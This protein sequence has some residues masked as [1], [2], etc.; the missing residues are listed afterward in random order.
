MAASGS[1]THATR[2]KAASITMGVRLANGRDSIRGQLPL[3]RESRADV[4]RLVEIVADLRQSPSRTVTLGD[5]VEAS[6]EG[7]VVMEVGE[8]HNR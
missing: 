3:E 6:K 5:G 4:L 1:C 2:R 7:R 8:E